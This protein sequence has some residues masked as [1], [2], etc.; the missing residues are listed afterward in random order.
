MGQFAQLFMRNEVSFVVTRRDAPPET[1]PL[2]AALRAKAL[3]AFAQIITFEYGSLALHQRGYLAT[4]L[5]LTED[6][7]MVTV[8]D[9]ET[10]TKECEDDTRM[11]MHIPNT[12]R[13][14]TAAR[15][16]LP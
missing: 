16:R 10:L 11:I 2:M 15:R 9:L 5:S 4:L 13:E 7:R 8:A 1:D 6:W 3:Q 14:L 12:L